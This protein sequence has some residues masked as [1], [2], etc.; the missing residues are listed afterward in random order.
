MHVRHSSQNEIEYELY[1]K[2][3]LGKV[4]SSKLFSEISR[5]SNDTFRYMRIPKYS[6]SHNSMRHSIPQKLSMK[7]SNYTGMTSHESG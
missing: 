5:L 4:L 1:E 7:T 2:T 6:T 3:E